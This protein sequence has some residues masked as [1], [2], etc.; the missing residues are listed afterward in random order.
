MNDNE[1][2]KVKNVCYEGHKDIVAEWN[3]EFCK[4]EK[5]FYIEFFRN[6]KPEKRFQKMSAVLEFLRMYNNSSK[7][8][9]DVLETIYLI[10]RK[11][12]T[13]YRELQ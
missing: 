10:F 1:W 8:I 3:W 2:R 9:M 5:W 4:W 6:L 12:V 7:S 13:V 11:T